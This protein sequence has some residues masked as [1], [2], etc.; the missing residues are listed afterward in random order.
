MAGRKKRWRGKDI[1]LAGTQIHHLNT[2]Q[3]NQAW[4]LFAAGTTLNQICR[5]VGLTNAQLNALIYE[6]LPPRGGRRTRL[7][8]FEE[9][10]AEEQAAIRSEAIEAGKGIS[11]VGVKVLEGAM[12]NSQS[13]QFL[14]DKILTMTQ[15]NLEW[16]ETMPPA[17]RPPLRSVLPDAH[18]IYVLRA[19]RQIG[20]GYR[21]AAMAYRMIYDDP[22]AVHPATRSALDLVGRKSKQQAIPG[23]G[24][25]SLPAAL[26]FLAE[27]VGD[28]EAELYM[29]AML[30]DVQ[31]WTPEQLE[32]FAETGEEPGTEEIKDAIDV[33]SS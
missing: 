27:A 26:A 20:R 5:I 1:A 25:D 6:G 21:D 33:T 4:V 30:R 10:L 12:K 22:V 29:E 11:H 24:K 32:R 14:I 23:A 15:E 7:Q 3:Y 2:D 8:S 16:L 17:D 18:T 13:A 19:L 9:R 31:K 28:K